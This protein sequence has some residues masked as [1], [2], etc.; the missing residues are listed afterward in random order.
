MD[1]DLIEKK[2][3]T[4]NE[5]ISLSSS[6]ST[7]FNKNVYLINNQWSFSLFNAYLK[8]TFVE[9]DK[10]AKKTNRWK[11]VEEEGILIFHQHAR[12]RS[13]PQCKQREKNQQESEFREY[14]LQSSFHR[15]WI[16][17][18]PLFL[19]STFSSSRQIEI[20]I[21]LWEREIFFF[22]ISSHFKSD[23]EKERFG[24]FSFLSSDKLVF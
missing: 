5:S 20:S 6:S 1:S 19:Q 11:E 13:P 8:D 16:I 21:D 22:I 18:Q 23:W 17:C 10:F 3:K 15:E 9:S 4:F 2:K 24:W 14:E 7:S 12:R